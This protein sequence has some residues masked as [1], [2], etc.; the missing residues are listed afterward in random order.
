MTF[1]HLLFPRNQ[2]KQV[3][4]GD[5]CDEWNN[6]FPLLHLSLTSPA[7]LSCHPASISDA[8]SLAT[9]HWPT[10][11]VCSF[12]LWNCI[13]NDKINIVNTI[14]SF[15]YVSMVHWFA[16]QGSKQQLSCVNL[17]HR[18]N[19]PMLT[20]QCLL[21]WFNPFIQMKVWWVFWKFFCRHCSSFLEQKTTTMSLHPSK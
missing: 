17:V 11:N 16:R 21:G 8:R 2:S 5:S 19:T 4:N 10:W 15:Y 13:E 12:R 3:W 14:L 20:Y 6:Q 7:A 1:I 18:K 9:S